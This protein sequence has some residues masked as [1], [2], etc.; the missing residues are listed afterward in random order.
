MALGEILAVVGGRGTRVREVFPGR[1]PLGTTAQR[2][3]GRK[4]RQLAW[5]S[6]ALTSCCVTCLF[7]GVL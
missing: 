1:T 3:E 7:P 2:K 6:L 5:P 4:E